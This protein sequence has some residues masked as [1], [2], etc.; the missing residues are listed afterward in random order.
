MVTRQHANPSYKADRE[1]R[2]PGPPPHRPYSQ[3]GAGHS[4]GHRAT[5]QRALESVHMP[6][7]CWTRPFGVGGRR[8]ER[9]ARKLHLNRL[10]GG[11]PDRDLDGKA[12]TVLELHDEA[13]ARYLAPRHLDS[14]LARVERHLQRRWARRWARRG[15]WCRARR[16][17]LLVGSGRASAQRRLVDAPPPRLL[18]VLE[19]R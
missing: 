3:H 1:H 18:L 11:G 13:I 12:K 5:V 7:L 19:V 2:P 14:H 16:R 15:G 6:S 17:A 9:R 8:L 4:L 10:P